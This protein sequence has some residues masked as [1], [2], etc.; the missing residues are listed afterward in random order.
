MP[1]PN[2]FGPGSNSSNPFEHLSDAEIIEGLRIESG[3]DP[4]TDAYR[5]ATN[6]RVAYT[7]N[8]LS[9]ASQMK[10]DIYPRTPATLFFILTSASYIT[11][12]EQAIG[13]PGKWPA[14]G[15]HA[16]HAHDKGKTGGIMGIHSGHVVHIY[17]KTGLMDVAGLKIEIALYLP[18]DVTP[19][20]EHML[21]SSATPAEK[22][23]LEN[24]LELSSAKR[25]QLLQA[26]RANADMLHTLGYT[27]MEAFI[28]SLLNESQIEPHALPELDVAFG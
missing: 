6:K 18:K 19:L 12:L 13:M 27:A 26:F 25:S 3:N 15:H 8:L 2:I 21:C 20:V 4:L 7:V 23:L 5:S 28:F 1:K 22:Y 10:P 9:I 17:G 16:R 14:E 24:P 11:T